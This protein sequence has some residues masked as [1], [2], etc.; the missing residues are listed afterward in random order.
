MSDP[1]GLLIAIEEV[2]S[3]PVRPEY[4]GGLILVP[5][6]PGNQHNAAAFELS[7]QLRAAGCTL[8]GTG[9]GYRVGLGSSTPA[10]LIPDFCVLRR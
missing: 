7:V 10:L 5:P 9:T 4:A 1:A 6:Q 2:S 3:E 8:T